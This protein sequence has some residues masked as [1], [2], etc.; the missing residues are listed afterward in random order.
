MH[1]WRLRAFERGSTQN[2]AAGASKIVSADT[3]NPVVDNSRFLYF[4]EVWFFVTEGEVSPFFNGVV[5][6]LAKEAT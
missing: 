5:V 1:D 4:V 2:S 6:E 3:L